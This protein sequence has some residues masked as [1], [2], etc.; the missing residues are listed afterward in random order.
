MRAQDT[1]ISEIY[2]KSKNGAASIPLPVLIVV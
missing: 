2:Q 1:L